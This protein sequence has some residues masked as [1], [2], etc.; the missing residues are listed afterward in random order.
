MQIGPEQ[1]VIPLAEGDAQ[2]LQRALDSRPPGNAPA[3]PTATIVFAALSV[4]YK[5]TQQ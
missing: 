5:E 2:S 4:R 1:E 3:S